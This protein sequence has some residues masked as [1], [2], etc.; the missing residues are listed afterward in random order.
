[1][2]EILLSCQSE[3]LSHQISSCAP[4]VK[5]KLVQQLKSTAASAFLL[6][7]TITTLPWLEDTQLLTPRSGLTYDKLSL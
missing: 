1:M 4:F 6:L 5:A 2:D 7:T 3:Q